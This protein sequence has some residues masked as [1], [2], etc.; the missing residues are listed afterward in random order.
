MNGK[1]SGTLV[2]FCQVS[3]AETSIAVPGLL[4]RLPLC[5]AL[6]PV[7]LEAVGAKALPTPVATVHLGAALGGGPACGGAH[8]TPRSTPHGGPHGGSS[9]PRGEGP[10]ALAALDV[11]LEGVGQEGAA[12]GGARHQA[13]VSVSGRLLYQH[14]AAQSA[15]LLMASFRH[16]ASRGINCLKSMHWS[17][18]GG[19]CRCHPLCR[20]E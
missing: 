13:P 4:L 9:A 2:W 5:L 1:D 19:C 18:H 15:T 11:V 20:F 16:W 17:P 14:A 7:D 3:G 10:A 6:R 12:A 8:G